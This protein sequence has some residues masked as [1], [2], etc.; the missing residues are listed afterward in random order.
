MI[1]FTQALA[2]PLTPVPVPPEQVVGGT[3]TTAVATLGALD[4]QEFG[5]WE[6]TVGAMRDVEVDELFVVIAGA[7]VLEFAE[8]GRRVDL[9]PGVVGRLAAGDRTVWTVSETLRKIW[10]A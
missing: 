9:V 8:D 7:G 10:V 2:V 6:M 5:V 1:G 3:P 4:E